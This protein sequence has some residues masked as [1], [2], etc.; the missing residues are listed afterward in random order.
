[1]TSPSTAIERRVRP[2]WIDRQDYALRQGLFRLLAIKDS[3]MHE[4][5]DS[6][7]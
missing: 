4:G 2:A 1:M 6:P 3:D 7:D 5:V